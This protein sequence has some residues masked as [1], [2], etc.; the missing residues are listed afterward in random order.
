MSMVEW[1][2]RG[3]ERGWK[4][5]EPRFKG[6]ADSDKMELRLRDGGSFGWLVDMYI[7]IAIC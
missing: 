2:R 6:A 1:E 4:K 3:G 5:V 7:C